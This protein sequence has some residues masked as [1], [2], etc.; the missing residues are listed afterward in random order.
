MRGARFEEWF[1][2]SRM[3]GLGNYRWGQPLRPQR[4]LGV[5]SDNLALVPGSLLPFKGQWQDAA[6]RLPRGAVLICL[7]AADCPQRQA[8]ERVGALLA[9]EGHQVTMLPAERFG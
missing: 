1:E 9:A 7:P 8:L 2:R 6:N 5:R 4:S 3:M